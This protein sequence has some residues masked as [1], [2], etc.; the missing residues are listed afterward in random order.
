MPE[1]ATAVLVSRSKRRERLLTGRGAHARR[2]GSRRDRMA[3]A[4]A[5][6]MP[7]MRVEITTPDG[8]ASQLQSRPMDARSHFLPLARAVGI[9]CGRSTAL[10]R[11]REPKGPIPTFGLPISRRS[12]FLLVTH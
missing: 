1:G 11:W 4:Q 10:H 12:H 6:Q 2:C 3:D 7:E 5:A 9:G 8:S